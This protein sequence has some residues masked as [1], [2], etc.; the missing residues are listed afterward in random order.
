VAVY[1][2][3]ARRHSPMPVPLTELRRLVYDRTSDA[4]YLG[5]STATDKAEH[6]KPMGPNLVR[7]D[8]W[9]AGPRIAWHLVLPHETSRGGHE[10][11]EPFDFAV[12]GDYA[13]VVYAGRLPSQ[14]LPTGTVMVFDKQNR[15]Y[16]GHMQPSGTRTGAVPM[17]ALQD[18]VHSI[19]A[20]RRADGEYLVWIEDDGYTKNVMYRWQPQSR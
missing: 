7:F 2:V 14:N 1:D 3:A 11:H 17:D 5:G 10:S 19:N 6:W 18:M 12:A 13:F 15:R 9:S 8:G 20:F 4:M 16:L